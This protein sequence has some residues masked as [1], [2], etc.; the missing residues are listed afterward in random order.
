MFSG[1]DYASRFLIENGA[2]VNIALPKSRLTPLHLAVV[3]SRDLPSINQMSGIIELLLLKAA[4][5]NACDI[6]FRSVFDAAV[7]DFCTLNC[8][9]SPVYTR[10]PAVSREG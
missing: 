9:C 8:R 5:A 10:N 2:D 1:D 3:Q 6:N 7:E 4:D